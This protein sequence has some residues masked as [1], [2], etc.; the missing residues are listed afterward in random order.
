MANDIVKVMFVKFKI[1][2]FN[3]LRQSIWISLAGLWRLWEG[4]FFLLIIIDT[5]K[6]KG[7][8]DLI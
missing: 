5:K 6:I 2:K 8:G 7:N 1:L 3:V 4:D